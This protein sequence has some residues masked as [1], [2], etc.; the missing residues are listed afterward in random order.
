MNGE[1]WKDIP[2]YE[3]IYQVSDLGNVRSLDRVVHGKGR[4]LCFK[5]GRILKPGLR[6]GYQC[7]CLCINGTQRTYYTHQLV[8]I[9]FLNHKPDGQNLVVD[10]INNIKTDNRLENLQV[11][12]QRYNSSKDSRG[13]SKYTGVY[14]QIKAKKW[15]AYITINGKRIHLGL[16]TDEEEAG[17]AYQ[18]ALDSINK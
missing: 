5:K 16:F 7:Y 12:T 3:G 17:L 8:A 4:Y 14:W 9:V 10:H 13:T 11:I 1:L 18:K 15:M 6:D 2:G